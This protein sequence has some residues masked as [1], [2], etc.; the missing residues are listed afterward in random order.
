M[1]TRT[2]NWF[3]A[4]VRYQRQGEDG[5]QTTVNE[6]YVIDALSFGEAEE[7]VTDELAT[8]VSGDFKIKNITPASYSEVFFSD[9]D[10]DDK[11]Y[12]AKL[13]FTTIDEEKGKEKRSSVYYLV[14]AKNS[15]GAVRNIDTVFAGSVFDYVISNITETRIMDVFEHRAP[16]ENNGGGA[17]TP[18]PAEGEKA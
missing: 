8:F 12:K 6:T 13:T 11:W 17:Q 9:M 5:G 3:E 15:S 2:T 7:A 18:A 16:K 4:S 14:Q 10:E 1:R